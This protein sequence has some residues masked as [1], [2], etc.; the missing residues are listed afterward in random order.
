[1]KNSYGSKCEIFA[2][3][4]SIKW[5]NGTAENKKI[6]FKRSDSRQEIIAK[7]TE[8]NFIKKEKTKKLEKKTDSSKKDLSTQLIEITEL[9]KSGALSEEDYLKA[10]NKLLG[11]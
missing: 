10:K 9:Y 6:R 11:K 7:L 5:R 2:V 4:R 8:L 3:G 1:M